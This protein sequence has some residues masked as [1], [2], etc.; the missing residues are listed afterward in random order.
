MTYKTTFKSHIN[1]ITTLFLAFLCAS[2]EKAAISEDESNDN[3]KP[4]KGE[5]T[6]VFG[7][8]DIDNAFANEQYDSQQSRTTTPI[9]DLCTRINL[10]IYVSDDA[11]KIKK[12]KSI[13]QDKSDASFGQIKTSLAKGSYTIVVVA[14]NGEGN[15]TMTSPS[16]ISFKDNKVTDTFYYYGD[17]EVDDNT[18]FDLTLKRAVAMVRL[19]VKDNTPTNIHNM[20]FYYTGGSSTF[21]AKT[22]YGCMD[23]KQTEIRTVP[24]SAYT[25]ESTYDIYTFPHAENKKLKIKVSALEK[26]SPS[27]ATYGRTIDDVSI[28]RN[29]ITRY[30]GYFYGEDPSTGRGFNMTTDDEWQY[31]DYEY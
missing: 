5:I 4:Q 30:S 7:T 3:E 22:G 12:I 27:K 29:Y 2:C 1:I 9:K 24:N 31:D 28:K 20:K 19:V 14:H 6:V 11:T 23:S 10:A 13:N 15:A 18:K 8:N 26:A 16:K 21:D 25:S 17:I